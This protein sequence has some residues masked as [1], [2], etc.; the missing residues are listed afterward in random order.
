MEKVIYLKRISLLNFKG[1]E[2]KTFE[3][4]SRESTIVGANGSGKSSFV[5]AFLWCLFRKDQFGRTDHQLKTIKNGQVVP[6]AECEV[7]LL[8]S[9][10]NEDVRFRRVYG[11]D[12]VRPK[13]GS[14][15]EFK[16]NSCTSYINDVPVKEGEYNLEVAKLCDETVFRAIT[17]PAY[18]PN[19]KPDEQRS[20]LFKMVGDISNEEIAR[21]NKEFIEFLEMVTGKSFELFKKEVNEKKRRI[22][23]DLKDIPAR[24]DELKKTIPEPLDWTAIEKQIAAKKQELESINTQL[25]DVSLFSQEQNNKR[26]ELR[27]QINELERANQTI[28]FSARKAKDDAIEKIKADVRQ[29]RLDEGNQNRDF[30]TKNARLDYLKKEK[31]RLE[32]LLKELGNEWV[33]IS[34]EKIVFNENEFLCPTCGEPY[35]Q[36][37][38]EEKQAKMIANF[39]SNKAKRLSL[40]E[41]NGKSRK[42]G[43]DEIN[44]EIR[45]IGELHKADT[46]DIESQI[47][48]KQNE[49]KALEETEFVMNEYL[50]EEKRAEY[51]SNL[52]QIEELNKILNVPADSRDNTELLENK[53]LI[54]QD[55]ERLSADLAK[56]SIIMNTQQRIEQLTEQQ[57]NM[58]QEL[59]DL[60]RKE[61]LQKNF[62][63]A[64]NQHYENAINQMFRLVRFNLFKQQVDGQIVPT[65]EANIDGVPYSTLNNAM[66]MNVGLDIIDAISRKEGIYAPIW[67]DNRE[68]VT[69]IPEIRAQVINLVVDPSEKE[70]RKL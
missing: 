37:K 65:C 35:K 67:L 45:T 36:D 30:N 48:T 12:W 25:T 19:L 54:N 16:G 61:F 55:I 23:N 9:V 3:F 5:T 49:L 43:L 40:N 6:K 28:S 26:L 2:N 8:F 53:R 22:Q 66:Q 14:E 69:S 64:K 11:E 38:V 44:E 27:N 41:D 58:N 7:E 68:S 63:Y 42:A 39:N 32:D 17:N 56:K 50:S 20:I 13:G 29:L 52:N 4:E 70:L 33:S 15:E 51:Q 10:N 24:I 31:V 62:E 18:F 57:T 21:D 46:S 1:V 47:Q 59:A 60:E 34:A